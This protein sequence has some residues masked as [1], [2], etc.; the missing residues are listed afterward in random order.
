MAAKDPEE[1]RR[2]VLGKATIGMHMRAHHAMQP[3]AGERVCA[4][5][6]RGV[7]PSAPTVTRSCS[8]SAAL[9]WR[10]RAMMMRLGGH[11]LLRA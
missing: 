1:G 8:T 4:Q 5:E 7:L 3:S 10:G 6:L 9:T 2:E 11:G